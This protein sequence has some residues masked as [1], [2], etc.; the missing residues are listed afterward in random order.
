MNNIQF[1]DLPISKELQKSIK[2]M[3]FEEATPVQSQSILPML[4]GKDI[5]AQAPTGTGKTCAFGI[6]LIENIDPSAREVLGLILCPTREL[7]I[8]ITNEIFKLAKHRRGIK[9][10]PVYGGQPI[11]RQIT[12]L[13]QKPQIIVATPGRLMDHMRRRTIRLNTLKYIVLDEADEMLNMGFREDIDEILKSVPDKRQMALF[14]ATISDEILEIIHQYQ[15]DPMLIRVAHKQITVPSIEQYYIEVKSGNKIE[16]LTRMIDAKNYKL[17]MVFCNTKRMVDELTEDLVSR[18]YPAQALHGD[19]KQS[20]RDRVMSKFRNGQVEILIATDVAARGIDVD[21]V[22]AVFNYDIP[23]DE[24]YYVHRI[25]RTGRAN[26]RGVSYTFVTGRQMQKLRDIMRY[27]KA[28][29]KMMKAPSLSDVE[30]IR[31]GKIFQEI[32][33]MVQTGQQ[34][35]YIHF[36]ESFLEED[37]NLDITT[38]DIAAAFLGRYAKTMFPQDQGIDILYDN[39]ERGGNTK[40]KNSVRLFLNIGKYD[41]VDKSELLKFFS[42]NIDFSTNLIENIDLRDQ[43]SF[44]TIPKNHLES[45]LH[46]INDSKYKGR[47]L[48]VEEANDRSRKKSSGPPKLRPVNKKKRK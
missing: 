45:F 47:M 28:P 15:D 10:V 37:D 43:Y 41:K 24:E 21:D 12:A 23:S 38:I 29:I 22:E 19:M 17:S 9:V 8:Q 48:V 30:Y 18:G 44:I 26:K 40:Q 42:K 20:Q 36:I 25:G 33:E 2:E 27:T 14:S 1:T 13:K 16:A 39:K 31:M 32:Q 6:P 35:R 11:E 7:A 5:V 34:Q 4:E 46:S 3:G